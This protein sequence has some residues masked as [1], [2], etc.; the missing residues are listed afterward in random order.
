MFA[1]LEFI[2]LFTFV[3]HKSVGDDMVDGLAARF[4]VMLVVYSVVFQNIWVILRFI[5]RQG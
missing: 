1:H 5:R 4:T 2:P 3:G